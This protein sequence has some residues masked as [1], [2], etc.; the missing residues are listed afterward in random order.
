MV[1]LPL[2]DTRTRGFRSSGVPV[3]G[4]VRSSIVACVVSS[5][6]HVALARDDVGPVEVSN[7]LV[8]RSSAP[9]SGS[10]RFARTWYHL[11]LDERELFFATDS[12]GMLGTL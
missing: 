3:R 1:L 5:S 6:D 10:P 9:T 8:S 4:S 7:E 11:Q 2:G 12:V